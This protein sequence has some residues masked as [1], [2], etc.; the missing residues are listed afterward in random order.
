[1]SRNGLLY[2]YVYLYLDMPGKYLETAPVDAV[3]GAETQPVR[4]AAASRRM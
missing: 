4:T 1:M 2:V 3:R